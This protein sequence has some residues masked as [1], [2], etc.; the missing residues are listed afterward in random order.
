MWVGLDVVGGVLLVGV[1]CVFHG[2]VLPGCG[3]WV[4]V[5][6]FLDGLVDLVGVVDPCGVVAEVCE[7]VEALLLEG[8]W[9]VS[10][11]FGFDEAVFSFWEDDEAVGG[12]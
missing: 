10:G 5:L 2:C 7:V 11:C 3:V 6:D 1:G 12:S 9:C 8:S 4:V